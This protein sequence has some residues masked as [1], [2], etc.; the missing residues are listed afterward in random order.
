MEIEVGEFVTLV[1]GDTRVSGRLRGYR[2]DEQG[3]LEVL[4]LD[5]MSDGFFIFS[6][7]KVEVHG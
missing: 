4:W 1:L 3:E 6:G 7:W 2:N 5:N